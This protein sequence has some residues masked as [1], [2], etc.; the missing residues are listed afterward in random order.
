MVRTV[1]AIVVLG[2]VCCIMAPALGCGRSSIDRLA[3]E[4]EQARREGSESRAALEQLAERLGTLQKAQ[5]ELSRQVRCF[6][7]QRSL[8]A[9]WLDHQR[10]ARSAEGICTLVGNVCRSTGLRP[11]TVEQYSR[12]IIQLVGFADAPLTCSP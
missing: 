9:L 11:R 3:A 4:L 7:A 6:D 12:R 2:T 1:R 10:A 5:D 8:K